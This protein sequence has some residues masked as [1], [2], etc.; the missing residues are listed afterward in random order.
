[1]GKKKL[2]SSLMANVPEK[3][4]DFKSTEQFV[5]KMMIL[6]NGTSNGGF[7]SGGLESEYKNN[8][9]IWV[10][11]EAE[12]LREPFLGTH[13]PID[14]CSAEQTNKWTGKK[15]RKFFKLQNFY[16]Q[17][18]ASQLLSIFISIFNEL[19][20]RFEL[21]YND[22]HICM[23]VHD[24]VVAVSKT[25]YAKLVARI[26]QYTHLL[27]W[28]WALRALNIPEICIGGAW[29]ES[30][31]IDRYWRKWSG[32]MCRT[33]SNPDGFPTDCAEEYTMDELVLCK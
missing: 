12:K 23:T 28:V 1:M 3:F 19:A 10:H 6:K 29:F 11:S 26:M 14:H 30:V 7:Y 16:C 9:D 24:E 33:D 2:T 5:E 4:N 21:G 25:K 18:G 15:E 31:Q 17:G 20:Q 8:I 27:T 13:P 22:A 32:D